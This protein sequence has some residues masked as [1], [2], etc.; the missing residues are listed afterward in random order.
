MTQAHTRARSPD[1]ADAILDLAEELI[2]TRGYNGFSYQDIADKLKIRKPS[3]HYHYPS[4]AA[5]GVAVIDRYSERFAQALSALAADPRRPAMAMVAEYVTPFLQFADTPDRVCL[6]GALA[7]ETM[8]LPPEM[9]QR[10]ARFFRQHQAWLGEILRRG[11]ER[12]EFVLSEKPEKVARMIFGALQGALLVK[13]TTG[14]VAQ[15]SDVVAVLKSQLVRAGA[16]AT[17]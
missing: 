13:R 8:A 11:V 1:T 7:G 5:L 9:R 2:Q 4:K 10:V 14:E 3:I 17:G 16:R 12:G 15:L 6:C